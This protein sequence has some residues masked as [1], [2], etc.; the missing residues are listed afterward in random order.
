[1]I[2]VKSLYL[3][4]FFL[5]LIEIFRPQLIVD[6]PGKQVRL[7]RKRCTYQAVSAA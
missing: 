3:Q 2:A 5:D 6:V 4:V 7:A 1:M